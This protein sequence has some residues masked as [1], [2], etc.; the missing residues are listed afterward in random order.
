MS[1]RTRL[2]EAQIADLLKDYPGLPSDYVD[3]L[4]TTGWGQA[5]SGR[6]VYEGP[7]PPEDIY[8]E[9]YE[10]PDVVLLG[11]D[12]HGYCLG[13]DFTSGCYGEVSDFGEWEPWSANERLAG[14]VES[15]PEG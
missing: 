5:A 6:M 12:Y 4:G 7:I 15:Q 13:Y 14:Y 2:T 3:Y 8:G 9:G 11:D 10:G 1:E